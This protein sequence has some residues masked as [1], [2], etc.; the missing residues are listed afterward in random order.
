MPKMN[1]D[2]RFLMLDVRV[3]DKKSAEFQENG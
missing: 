1:I 2:V 3:F